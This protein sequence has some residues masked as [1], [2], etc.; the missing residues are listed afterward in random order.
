MWEGLTEFAS[1]W[2]FFRDLQFPQF[3]FGLDRKIPKI[4]IFHPRDFLSPESEF[5]SFRDFYPR[6]SGFFTFGY[7]DKKPTLRKSRDARKSLL[8]T[9]LSYY[10]T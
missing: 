9:G 5:F 10:R 1:R 7:L 6:D 4:P 8:R 2:D 3:L